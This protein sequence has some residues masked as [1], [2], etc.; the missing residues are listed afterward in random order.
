MVIVAESTSQRRNPFVRILAAYY[1]FFYLALASF[2]PYTTLVLAEKGLSI[3]AIGMILSL[4]AFVGIVAQPVMGMLSDRL[5]NRRTILILCLIVSPVAGLGLYYSN[6]Y[7]ALILSSVL[8]AWFQASSGPLSDSLA[9]EIGSKVGI[10][11]GNI[12]LWGALSFSLG[13]FATGF[14]YKHTGYHASLLAYLAISM[15]ALGLIFLYPRTNGS[16]TKQS[17]SNQVQ[18]VFLNK[19]FLLFCGICSLQSLCMSV[20]FA[21]FP[22]YFKERS[23][24]SSWLGTAYAIAAII[25]VPMFWVSAQLNKRIG[26]FNVLCLASALYALK[27]FILFTSDNIYIVMTVQLL[28]GI[29]FAFY[30]C[31]AVEVVESLSNGLNKASYQT[32]FAAVTSGLAG[33][34]G[35]AAGGFIVDLRGAPF[36]YLILFLISLAASVLFA[37]SRVSLN[38]VRTVSGPSSAE[39]RSA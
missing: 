5:T 3:T 17:L 2:F 26:R 14:A 8:F 29:A 11:F 31:A 22:I 9:I 32:V 35:S 33:I 15:I 7:T 1:F 19:P 30:A 20:N 12:R 16:A 37:V 25:E 28:D 13:T 27:A 23:F 34:I 10:S 24:D 38:K 21:F 18:H 6:G 36:L 39:T 4:W